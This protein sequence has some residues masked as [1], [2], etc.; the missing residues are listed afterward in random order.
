MKRPAK[1]IVMWSAPHRVGSA[2]VQ[3]LTPTVMPIIEDV[4]KARGTVHIV[5]RDRN[6]WNQEKCA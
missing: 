4:L 1:F 5:Q 2:K 6:P 3:K